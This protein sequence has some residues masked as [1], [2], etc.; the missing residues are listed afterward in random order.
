[1]VNV[2]DI[3][4]DFVLIEKTNKTGKKKEQSHG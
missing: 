4:L 3:Q 2:F 1:M